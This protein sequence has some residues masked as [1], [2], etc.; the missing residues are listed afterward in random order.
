MCELCESNSKHARAGRTA[1]TLVPLEMVF[2]E[3]VMD[4]Q[5]KC[6]VANLNC[7]YPFVAISA[8]VHG[9]VYGACTDPPRYR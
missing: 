5:Q 6:F 1:G 2:M 7:M 3:R 9:G 4:S 8:L